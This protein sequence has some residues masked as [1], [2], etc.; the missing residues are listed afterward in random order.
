MPKWIALLI[1]PADGFAQGY[2]RTLIHFLA[3]G[4]IAGVIVTA[5]ICSIYGKL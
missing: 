2:V 5:V 1:D 4:A 3:Y